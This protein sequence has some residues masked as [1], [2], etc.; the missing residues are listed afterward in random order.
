M[1]V[2]EAAGIPRAGRKGG[3]RFTGKIGVEGYGVVGRRLSKLFGGDEDSLDTYIYGRY[4]TGMN[5]PSRKAG[6]QACAL[7]FVAA[8]MRGEP[9]GDS[10][11]PSSKRRH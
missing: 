2:E 5:A 6:V 10:P 8:P 3:K 4:E 7:P 9:P 11:S 1:R